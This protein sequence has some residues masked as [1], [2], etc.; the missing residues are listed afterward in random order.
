[1]P[2]IKSHDQNFY[3]P[4]HL[5]QTGSDVFQQR[6]CIKSMTTYK[7]TYE[8]DENNLTELH[9]HANWPGFQSHTVIWYLCALQIS[10]I[11]GGRV[12]KSRPT[13][14]QTDRRTLGLAVTSLVM[15]LHLDL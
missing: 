3:K 10:V 5:H 2:T 12:I 9:I 15:Y 4:L 1:M 6:K 14:R 8:P 7:Y 13:D 11:S